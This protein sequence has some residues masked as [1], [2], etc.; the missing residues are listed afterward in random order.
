MFINIVLQTVIA[1]G[2]ALLMHRLAKSTVIRGTLLL[3][4]LISNVIAAMLWFWMLDYQIGMVNEFIEWA[5]LNRIAF[6]GSEDWAIPTIAAV[7]IWRHMGYTAL[8]IF[9]GLQIDPDVRLRGRLPRRQHRVAD[10]LADHPAAAAAGPGAGPG[11]H[12]DRLVPGLRH[13][14]RDHQ[15]RTGQRH[16]SHA[17]LHLPE[18]LHRVEFGYASALS[19][20]FFLILA[21]VALV[22]MKFLKGDE[23]DLA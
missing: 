16:P 9:A 22:Q 14:G 4:F 2:L 7:N 13:R 5:G 8:L 21:P 11:G 6:F 20:I 10:V 17:V 23:S 3:P 18:G 19:V 1:L 12:G 15:G